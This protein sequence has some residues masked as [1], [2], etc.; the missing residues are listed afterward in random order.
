M[1][2]HSFNTV[3]A[4]LVGLNAAVIIDSFVFWTRTNAAKEKNFHEGRYW[5]FGTPEY[6]SR[7]FRY[8]TARQIEHAINKCVKAGLITKGNFNKA[9]YDRTGW[10]ALTDKALEVYGVEADCLQPRPGLIP[11]NCSI[12]STN[13]RNG[14]N[15]FVPPIPDTKPDTKP[16]IN[17]K[18]K[19][20][21]KENEICLPKPE[22]E[23]TYYPMPTTQKEIAL[24]IGDNPHDIEPDAVAAWLEVRKKKKC[25]VTPRVWQ[26][27]NKELAKCANPR[28]AFDLMVLRGWTSVKREWVEKETG[29]TVGGYN[30][31]DTSWMN[32]KDIFD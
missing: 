3:I 5:S 29:G 28:E 12:D 26:L 16:D 6:F 32:K 17:N 30:H 9:G 14:C 2:S 8:L 22:Y 18:E 20:Y 11:Q 21:K 19:I 15:K 10:Y 13:L 24:A 7:F 27:L 1:S 23:E 4:E 31:T 25:P